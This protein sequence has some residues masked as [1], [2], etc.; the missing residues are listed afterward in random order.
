MPV[1]VSSDIGAVI[2]TEEIERTITAMVWDEAFI[3]DLFRFKTLIGSPTATASFPRK[4]KSGSPIPAVATETTALA[5]IPLT[6]TETSCTVSRY[7][8][9]RG[10]SRSAEEDN[11]L[12]E[13]IYNQE[14]V[15]DAT[16]LF[17]ELMD[18]TAAAL[19]ASASSVVGTTGVALTVVVAASAVAAQRVKKVRGKQVMTLHDLQ[20]AQLHNSQLSSTATAW[21]SF[22]QPVANSGQYGGTILGVDVVSS[23]LTPVSG[24]DR[25]GCIYAVGAAAGGMDEYAAFAFVMKRLPSS[26]QDQNISDDSKSWASFM[27]FGV[28]APAV[29]FATRILSVNS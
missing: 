3:A 4:V 16:I 26:L 2:N 28:C 20:L 15:S 13:Q 10:I 12:G 24:P 8:I 18:T 14:F 6:F 21:Q 27:R 23:G 19:F 29:N 22:F 1:I 11:I 25:I 5:T 17:G 9:S 7:G